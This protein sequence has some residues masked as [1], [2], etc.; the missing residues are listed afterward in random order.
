MLTLSVQWK[1]CP[2]RVAP[3]K[4]DIRGVEVGI[5]DRQESQRMHVPK[6]AH[7][8]MRISRCLLLRLPRLLLKIGDCKPVVIAFH[9]RLKILR[10]APNLWPS[11]AECERVSQQPQ[12]RH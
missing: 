8:N 1:A 6:T 11:V 7:I 10:E 12:S 4:T 9:I 2:D 3:G 5:A